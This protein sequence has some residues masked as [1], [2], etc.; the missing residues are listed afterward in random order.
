MSSSLTFGMHGILHRPMS[1][2]SVLLLAGVLAG[3][4]FAEVYPVLLN[5][6][7]PDFAT[8]TDLTD[9]IAP[10]ANAVRGREPAFHRHVRKISRS[11]RKIP[12]K[13]VPVKKGHKGKPSEVRG[14][15]NKKVAACVELAEGILHLTTHRMGTDSLVEWIPVMLSNAGV[16]SIEKA[17][18]VQLDD[19]TLLQLDLRERND[20][21]EGGFLDD[22]SV[23][24][25]DP[26]REHFLI[27]AS[28][29][30]HTEGGSAQ[31]NFDESCHGVADIRDGRLKVGGWTCQEGNES[32]SE[33][34]EIHSYSRTTG[35][36]PEFAYHFRDG[37]LYQEVPA[38]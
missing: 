27:S 34:G 4:V 25:I 13:A 6:R 21:S 14:I 29:S 19:A 38:R 12:C 33:S 10:V 15:Q 30:H 7:A 3:A 16:S 26:V 1:P 37:Y 22:R 23:V 31:G 28:R 18:L 5:P 17:S 9:T 8:R 36:E 20:P 35:P 32:E 2:R 24:L 11:A